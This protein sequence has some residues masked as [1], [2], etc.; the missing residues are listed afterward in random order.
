MD[1]IYDTEKSYLKDLCVIQ[2]VY[3]D[4]SGSILSSSD[5]K[6]LFANIHDVLATSRKLK[7]DLRQN[8]IGIVFLDNHLEIQSVYS[9][10]CKGSE[11][12]VAKLNE[13]SGPDCPEGIREYLNV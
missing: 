5:K 13:Y 9:E 4:D 12:A 8:S 11:S 2:Q 1:E 7:S 6:I 3:L 10:Y